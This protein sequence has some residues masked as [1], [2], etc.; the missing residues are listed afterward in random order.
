MGR[1]WRHLWGILALLLAAG[2]ATAA[3]VQISS[4]DP[5]ALDGQV[6]VAMSEARFRFASERDAGRYDFTITEATGVLWEA[7]TTGAEAANTSLFPLKPE[8]TQTP[9]DIAPGLFNVT[10][11]GPHVLI[12]EAKPGGILDIVPL[13][14]PSP[15]RLQE[16]TAPMSAAQGQGVSDGPRF[17]CSAGASFQ[18]QYQNTRG[19]PAEGAADISVRGALTASVTSGTVE[20]VDGSGELR[21]LRLGKEV[22]PTGVPGVGSRV[23]F[24]WMVL[25]GTGDLDLPAARDWA[26]CGRA[27][28]LLVDGKATWTRASGTASQEEATKKFEDAV[29]SLQGLFDVEHAAR[30]L[31]GTVDDYEAQGDAF[32]TIDGRPLVAPA[33]PIPSSLTWA[34]AVVLI[35]GL[36]AKFAAILYTRLSASDLLAHPRRRLLHDLVVAN[37]GIHKREL[38]RK[39]GGAWGPF[40]FHLDML[41]KGGY[42]R[43][44]A[45]SGYA[46]VFA[47]DGKGPPGPVIPHPV[48][49]AIYDALPA[50]GSAVGFKA[51]RSDL[52]LTAQLLG[53]HMN[54]LAARGLVRVEGTAF[55]PKT[56]AR[57]QPAHP[58]TDAPPP[59]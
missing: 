55:G 41:V 26:A 9:Y 29:V 22:D 39:V 33:A 14:P 40:T 51:L 6:T 5:V 45:A 44:D 17:E 43:I 21:S 3:D 10:F 1:P 8:T 2:S 31:P 20:F 37:P 49:R 54:G 35:L 16:L 30:V 27:D 42:L 18:G 57:V 25:E 15:G 32:V 38:H 28:G 4:S 13:E 52:G 34:A 23:R 48:P 11:D 36:A 56:A 24:R 7:S 59:R 19:W 12:V 53:H 58:T 50:D 46:Q 47:R